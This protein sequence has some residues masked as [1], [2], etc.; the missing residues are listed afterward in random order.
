MLIL[1]N[2]FLITFALFC[3][4]SRIDNKK[5]RKHRPQW[6]LFS[7]ISFIIKKLN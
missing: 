2:I 7:V 3:H 5:A 4:N 6:L 1:S